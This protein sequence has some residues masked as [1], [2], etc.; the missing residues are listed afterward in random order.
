M[1]PTHQPRLRFGEFGCAEF[2]DSMN[3]DQCIYLL[4]ALACLRHNQSGKGPIRKSI[5]T[6]FNLGAMSICITTLC[7]NAFLCQGAKACG[8]NGYRREPTFEDSRRMN[9]ILFTFVLL[10]SAYCQPLQITQ[11]RQNELRHA[12]MTILCP[13]PPREA[14]STSCPLYP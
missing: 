13:A 5:N 12:W 9:S 6:N 2:I 14:R 3:F 1:V 8:Y 7:V 4:A 11:T 10:C